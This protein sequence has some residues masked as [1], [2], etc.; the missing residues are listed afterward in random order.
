M[1]CISSRTNLPH[2]VSLL[3][4]TFPHKELPNRY[5]SM[6]YYLKEQILDFHMIVELKLHIKPHLSNFNLK[7]K[8]IQLN[9]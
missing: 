4:K 7:N 2:T 8:T 6:I 5:A 1:T 9:V 3:K